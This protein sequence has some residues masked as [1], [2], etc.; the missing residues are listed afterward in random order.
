MNNHKTSITN[1]LG[2]SEN[3][4]PNY[5]PMQALGI[6]EFIKYQEW[7]Y[8]IIIPG[9]NNS[10][11]ADSSREVGS[12]VDSGKGFHADWQGDISDAGEVPAAVQTH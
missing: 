8:S 4:F 9:T 7:S 12:D 5:Y 2:E 11:D 1:Q 10:H 6:P 3:I